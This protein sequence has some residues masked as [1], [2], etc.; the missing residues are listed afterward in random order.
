ME[1]K[2]IL[3]FQRAGLK[4][5]FSIAICQLDKGLVDIAPPPIFS[6]FVGVA[7][8][9]ENRSHDG[10]LGSV[11]I[12]RRVAAANMAA[13]EALAQMYPCVA[14]FQTF[15]ASICIGGNALNSIDVRA[16][17]THDVLSS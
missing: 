14:Q 11:F 7:S 9:H 17:I 15:F 1:I 12:P 16:T 3:P 6:W 8:R 5:L 4:P 13:D 10:M 2:E